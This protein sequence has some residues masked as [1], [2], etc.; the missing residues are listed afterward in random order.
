MKLS[1]L[2]NINSTRRAFTLL[3]KF[4]PLL[5]GKID[6]SDAIVTFTSSAPPFQMLL[7]SFERCTGN[8]IWKLTSSESLPRHSPF[9]YDRL[10]RYLSSSCQP[11]RRRYA[12]PRRG[13]TLFKSSPCRLINLLTSS[14][15]LGAAR[16][17]IYHNALP[18]CLRP[19]RRPRVWPEYKLFDHTSHPVINVALRATP[20]RYLFPLTGSGA[21][22]CHRP[23]R[24]DPI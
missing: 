4:T 8:A 9:V 6:F 11:Q 12:S 18:P 24:D 22:R 7:P 1:V 3:S 16:R 15:T 5:S 2:T 19:S 20:P 10:S 14:S 21:S 17:V 23:I 13:V